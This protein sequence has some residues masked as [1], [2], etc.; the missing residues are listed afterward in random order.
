MHINTDLELDLSIFWHV[1][2]YSFHENKIPSVY[3]IRHL[4]FLKANFSIINYR[5]MVYVRYE[6]IYGSYA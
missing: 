1:L 2:R 4:G 3:K 6:K 5:Q